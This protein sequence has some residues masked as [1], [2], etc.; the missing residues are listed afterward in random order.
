MLVQIPYSL[1]ELLASL[2]FLR[3]RA[4]AGRSWLRVLLF[5]DIDEG[6]REKA[7]DEFDARPGAVFRKIW[8]GGVGLPWNL[9]AAVIIGLS[10]LFTR[11]TLGADGAMA[12]ADH[13]IG[14]L[15]LTVISLA[16]AEV[17][18]PLRFLLMPLGAA[19]LV[20]PFIYGADSAQ[21]AASITCGLALM[22]LSVR[23]GPISGSYGGWQAWIR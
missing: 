17:A 14:S 7:D 18:R 2:Q 11:L 10:L 13:L 4:K 5:G 3:R 6:K 16:A 21:I 23:R 1:D 19:L 12:N 22:V 8:T 20:T 15:A 9:A